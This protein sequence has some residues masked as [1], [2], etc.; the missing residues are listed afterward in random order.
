MKFNYNQTT[1]ILLKDFNNQK[2]GSKITTSKTK[3]KQL[4]K[5]KVAYLA[6]SFYFDNKIKIGLILS[7]V[8]SILIIITLNI[9]LL[10][11]IVSVLS[12]FLI[13]EIF[14]VLIGS[15]ALFM[16]TKMNRLTK[17]QLLLLGIFTIFAFP[18]FWSGKIIFK[19]TKNDDSKKPTPKEYS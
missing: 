1:L 18:F 15:I 11:S 9:L 8:V 12:L 5:N 7:I 6:N 10:F 2:A 19:D 16:L 4:I 3:A 14:Y 13:V 17:R